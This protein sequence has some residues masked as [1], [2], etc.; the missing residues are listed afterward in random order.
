MLNQKKKVKINQKS[1]KKKMLQLK[2]VLIISLK[3]F[4]ST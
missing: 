1:N 4:L 3:V 2:N